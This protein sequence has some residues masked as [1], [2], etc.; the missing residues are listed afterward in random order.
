MRSNHIT[1]HSQQGGSEIVFDSRKMTYFRMIKFA[2]PLLLSTS[3][4]SRELLKQKC[5]KEIREV[6]F[7][8]TKCSNVFDTNSIFSYFSQRL[9]KTRKRYVYSFDNISISRTWLNSQALL[10]EHFEFAAK[11]MLD[12]SA[13]STSKHCCPK[14]LPIGC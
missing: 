11:Q 1:T 14:L 5:D 4:F 6:E 12:R 13:T 9:P 7:I 2:R 8:E 3:F 10:V